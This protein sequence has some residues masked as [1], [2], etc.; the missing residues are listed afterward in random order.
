MVRGQ[1]R[2]AGA[3]SWS[4]TLNNYTEEELN[5]LEN[6]I[7]KLKL[8]YICWSLE[9]APKTGTPHVQGYLFKKKKITIGGLTK[10]NNRISLKYCTKTPEQNINYCSGMCEKKGFTLNPSF[11]EYGKRPGERQGKKTDLDKFKEDITERKGEISKLELMTTHTS[12]YAKYP[13]FADEYINYV[14]INN[15]IASPI[16]LNGWET[17]IKEILLGDVM[18]SCIIWIWSEEYATGKHLSCNI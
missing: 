5:Q 7:N 15:Y 14:R 12:V 1:R 11:I 3:G 9:I 13:E 17:E 16:E 6:A 10:F 8:D 2:D 4:F 18:H